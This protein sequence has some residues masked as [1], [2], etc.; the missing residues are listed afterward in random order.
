[1]PQA[2]E[3]STFFAAISKVDQVALRRAPC[4]FE[5]LEHLS[6]RDQYLSK[7]RSISASTAH[8]LATLHVHSQ[9]PIAQISYYF[10][11]TEER[12]IKWVRA[13]Y[14][15]KPFRWN[16]WRRELNLYELCHIQLKD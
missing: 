1:M 2:N 5:K 9:V 11:V 6:D 14:K 10:N 12:V 7:S 13:A 8:K 16:K 15:Q 4:R 3:L